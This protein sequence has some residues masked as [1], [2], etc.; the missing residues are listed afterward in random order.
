MRAGGRPAA[1]RTVDA[2]G[3]ILD[4]EPL[5]GPALRVSLQP[6]LARQQVGYRAGQQM[7]AVELGGDLDMQAQR[8]PCLLDQPGLGNSSGKVAAEPDERLDRAVDH[9]LARLDGVEALLARR[10]ETIEFREL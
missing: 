9:P 7:R 8:P 5:I 1:E 10:L 4:G 6:R 2:G 3:R